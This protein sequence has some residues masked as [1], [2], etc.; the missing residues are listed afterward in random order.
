MTLTLWRIKGNVLYVPENN[1]HLPHTCWLTLMDGSE[2]LLGTPVQSLIKLRLQL[3]KSPSYCKYTFLSEFPRQ[4]WQTG[5]SP[6]AKA[7]PETDAVSCCQEDT[8]L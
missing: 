8:L 6:Q 7:R 3:H 1:N 2:V 5:T 4:K